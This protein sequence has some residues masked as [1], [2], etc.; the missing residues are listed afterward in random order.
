MLYN[1]INKRLAAVWG[2]DYRTYEIINTFL[3]KL[4]KNENENDRDDKFIILQRSSSS[5]SSVK[6]L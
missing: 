6:T 1:F 5:V 3:S 4:F 2:S